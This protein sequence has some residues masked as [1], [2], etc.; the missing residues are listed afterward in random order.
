[1]INFDNTEVAFNDK[2]A[3]HLKRARFLFKM[4]GSPILVKG[5]SALLQLALWLHLPVEWALK[6]TVFAHFC[7]GETIDDCDSTIGQL[8]AS[9]IYTILD[10]SAEGKEREAD[11]DHTKNQILAT[12]DKAVREKHIPYA[13]FKPTG[14]SRFALLEKVQAGQA[15]SDVEQ[16]EFDRIKARFEEIAAYAVEKDV[17]VMV[18]AE[19][20]QIQD[21]VDALVED[22]M[23]KYNKNKPYVYNTL[24]MYR[25]DRL[26]YLKDFVARARDNGVFAAFKLVRGA[27]ME[28]ERAHAAR[29]NL[30]SPI[31]PDK[32]STDNAF[33]EAVTYCLNNVDDV[34]VNIGTH[35]EISCARATDTMR[36]L[37]LPAAHEHISFAQLLGMSDHI[38]Y[39]L[40]EAGYNVCK[41]VPY[42]P[43]KSVL[44]YL[45]RRAEENTSVAGQTSRE[46][47]LIKK[48]I[49][50]RRA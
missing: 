42:G 35:N 20:T 16:A 15:L 43:V 29:N 28:K 33:D 49:A 40:A 25:Q 6:P 5:G 45:V 44:P 46:L 10:Y 24:Q 32:A 48:E 47:F 17:P 19:E 39:N 11:F 2:D 12:I 14:L 4:V 18:D 7:G 23:F 34:A 1:M 31:Y 27:Y 3:R 37:S 8:G 22:L 38:S 26:E 13:V 9:G 36:S 41:Y 30:P 50:R 21:L